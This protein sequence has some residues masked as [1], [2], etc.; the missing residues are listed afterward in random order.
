MTQVSLYRKK[1]IKRLYIWGRFSFRSKIF[2]LVFMPLVHRIVSRHISLTLA[3]T[4]EYAS[5]SPVSSTRMSQHVSSHLNLMHLPIHGSISTF[6]HQH[7]APNISC[8]QIYATK[9]L[10][11]WPTQTKSSYL[12]NNS[13]HIVYTVRSS[14]RFDALLSHYYTWKFSTAFSFGFIVSLST[15]SVLC[16]RKVPSSFNPIVFIRSFHFIIKMRSNRSLYF[17]AQACTNIMTD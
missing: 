10:V 11:K 14:A 7:R 13:S 15:I 8:I 3:I 1:T 6:H 2:F 4:A 17:N 9:V 5:P 16:L 12:R